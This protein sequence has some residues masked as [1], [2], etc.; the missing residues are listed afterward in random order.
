MQTSTERLGCLGDTVSVNCSAVGRPA[1]AVFLYQ[2]GT[3]MQQAL[4]NL[5]YHFTLDS[6]WKFGAYTCVSNNRV[7]TANVTLTFKTKRKILDELLPLSSVSSTSRHWKLNFNCNLH[8]IL[9]RNLMIT[10]CSIKDLIHVN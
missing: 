6:E 7:G 4:N 2:N 1:P 3:L 8:S 9:L 10:Y 5:S